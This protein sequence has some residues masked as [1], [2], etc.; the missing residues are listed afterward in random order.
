LFRRVFGNLDLGGNVFVDGLVALVAGVATQLTG[1]DQDNGSLDLASAERLLLGVPDKTHGLS[2]DAVEDIVDERVHDVHR[3]LRDT[4]FGMHLTKHLVDVQGEGLG[5]A[6]TTLAI[7]ADLAGGVLLFGLSA[8]LLARM[9]VSLLEWH[10]ES[11]KIRFVDYS[12]V[13]CWLLVVVVLVLR[14]LRTDRRDS[15]LV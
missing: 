15:D 7:L 9:C 11:S 8:A 14:G 10:D 6:L 2:A 12:T 1:E 5:A 4:G 3:L 13:G